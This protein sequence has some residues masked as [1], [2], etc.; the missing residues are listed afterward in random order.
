MAQAFLQDQLV[1]FELRDDLL[2]PRILTVFLPVEW[3]YLTWVTAQ[4]DNTPRAVYDEWIVLRN[5]GDDG[6][7][8][9]STDRK[10]LIEGAKRKRYVSSIFA[11]YQQGTGKL[12]LQRRLALDSLLKP[13]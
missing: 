2:Q 6:D 11:R 9:F 13:T 4:K 8:K 7:V 10:R 1:Q 5:I 3:V 12:Y